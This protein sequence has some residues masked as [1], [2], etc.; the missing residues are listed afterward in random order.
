MTNHLPSIR[1]YAKV[2][3]TTNL[4][5]RKPAR[6]RGY[7]RYTKI[8][9]KDP[10]PRLYYVFKYE[11]AEVIVF[12][13][14]SPGNRLLS[15]Y[16]RTANDKRNHFVGNVRSHTLHTYLPVALINAEQTAKQVQKS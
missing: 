11:L 16:N 5:S 15:I 6:A 14:V 8:P 2:T 1:I 9:E 7:T 4:V 12:S 13:P 3:V 10:P